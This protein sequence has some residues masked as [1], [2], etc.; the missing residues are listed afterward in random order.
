MSL[1]FW[2][3]ASMYTFYEVAET[4]TA[5]LPLP[6][7]ILKEKADGLL[8]IDPRDPCS[9]LGHHLKVAQLPYTLYL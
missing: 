9:E 7:I 2:D 6:L 1:A 5:L 8:H 4:P 3:L